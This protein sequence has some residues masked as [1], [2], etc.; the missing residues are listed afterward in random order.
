MGFVEG[1]G[2]PMIQA[3]LEDAGL[4]Y[5]RDLEGDFVV[6]FGYDDELAGH[7]RFLLAASGDDRSQFCLRG[8]VLKRV[9]RADWDRQI[10]LCNEWNALYKLPKVYLE[11]EDF[12]ISATGRI[13]CEQWLNLGPGIHQELVNH[14]TNSFFS[15][16]FGF[17]RWRERQDA[18]HA[19]GDDLPDPLS[20][21]EG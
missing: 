1:F 5:L 4:H 15:A 11:V 20:D 9:P 16:C 14:L 19:L 17:W 2:Q 8:D 7:P 18:L 6:E 21:D 12:N 10:R 13:L 3:F